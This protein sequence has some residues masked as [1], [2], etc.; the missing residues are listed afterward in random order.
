MESRKACRIKRIVS[1]N[2]TAEMGNFS[3]TFTDAC[4]TSYHAYDYFPSM[5]IWSL[6]IDTF[7]SVVFFS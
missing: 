6:L 7:F 1:I 5:T 3:G 4:Q 2:E